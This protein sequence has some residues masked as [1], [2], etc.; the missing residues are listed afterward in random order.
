MA[1]SIL[2]EGTSQSHRFE[3]SSPSIEIRVLSLPVCCRSAAFD[4]QA[5]GDR[6]QGGCHWWPRG[7][8]ASCTWFACSSAAAAT[9]GPRTRS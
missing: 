5:S 1:E 4:K 6:N 8:T 9:A 7:R 2:D 3:I